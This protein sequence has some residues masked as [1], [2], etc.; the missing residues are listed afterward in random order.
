[1]PTIGGVSGER[2]VPHYGSLAEARKPHDN[3]ALGPLN[4]AN[5]TASRIEQIVAEVKINGGEIIKVVDDSNN[6]KYLGT[7]LDVTG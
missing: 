1:M 3:S 5:E 2:G 6:A 4:K 7:R